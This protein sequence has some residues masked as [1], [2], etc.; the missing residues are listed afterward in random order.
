MRRVWTLQKGVLASQ[1]YCEF[2]DGIM[3][4]TAGISRIDEETNACEIELNMV[5]VEFMI[6][7]GLLRSI[8]RSRLEDSCQCFINTWNAIKLRR[9]SK[10]GDEIICFAQLLNLEVQSIIDTN[11]IEE[12]VRRCISML[13][14]VP[15]GV[16]YTFG[17]KLDIDGYRWAPLSFLQD[18]TH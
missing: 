15:L 12:R 5:P 17:P 6:V 9:T 18:Q 4:V 7:I 3:D 8:Q 1:L 14:Y 11:N 10:R 13:P 16:L 2:S